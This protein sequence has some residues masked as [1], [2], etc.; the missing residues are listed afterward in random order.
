MAA[1]VATSDPIVRHRI[2]FAGNARFLLY[3]P[4]STKS[5]SFYVYVCNDN[6]LTTGNFGRGDRDDGTR[7]SIWLGEG[8][9]ALFGFWEKSGGSWG[10]LENRGTRRDRRLKRVCV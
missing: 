9:G 7:V 3:A 8:F 2:A 4:S 6:R 5:R 10:S 1:V